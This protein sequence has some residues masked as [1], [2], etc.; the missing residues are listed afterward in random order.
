MRNIIIL[1]YV[2]ATKRCTLFK[3][4]EPKNNKCLIE[5]AENRGKRADGSEIPPIYHSVSFRGEKLSAIAAT[6]IPA[7]TPLIITG[8]LDPYLK[9]T[10]RVDTAGKPV[11]EWKFPIVVTDW[12]FAGETAKSIAATVTANLARGK[13]E[14][15]FPAQ[16]NAGADYLLTRQ[17]KNVF[18]PY[19]DAEVMQTGTFGNAKVW[20]KG[21]GWLGPQN[22]VVT[23]P[24][25]PASAE[26]V[27]D[28]AEIAALKA[29]LLALKATQ[30]GNP[31]AQA[32]A[33][34]PF[35]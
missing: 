26:P 9:N 29:E 31:L 10:G 35:G 19:N 17:T 18:R 6:M 15:V 12:K 24:V 1:P 2:H 4:N 30:A 3:G 8:Y 16:V 7:G 5:F 32:I 33:V 11:L 27:L 25:A 20:E 13:V 14:G 28:S 22:Q 21:K 34:D 23:G